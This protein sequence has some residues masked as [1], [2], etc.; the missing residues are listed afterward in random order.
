[1]NNQILNRIYKEFVPPRTLWKTTNQTW[2]INDI[3]KR[4]TRD[5]VVTILLILNDF[6]NSL[7]NSDAWESFYKHIRQ[8]SKS[9]QAI[10]LKEG[11]L[12]P[13]LIKAP[14]DM[15][16]HQEFV[17]KKWF[18][19]LQEI[20]DAFNLETKDISIPGSIKKEVEQEVLVA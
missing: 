4:T 20:L 16:S 9:E 11:R 5:S 18:Q 15:H 8:L 13:H 19:T 2:M 12:Y 6:T 14:N 7:E 17:A 10:I 1:M 3:L